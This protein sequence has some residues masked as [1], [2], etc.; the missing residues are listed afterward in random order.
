MNGS[1]TETW[2][3]AMD[4]SPKPDRFQFRL[5]TLVSVA[6]V[7]AWVPGRGQAMSPLRGFADFRALV[8]GG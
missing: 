8:S 2:G 3:G 5:W 6:V 1:R 4:K 7:G